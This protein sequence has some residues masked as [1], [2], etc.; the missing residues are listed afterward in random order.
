[1]SSQKTINALLFTG[2]ALCLLQVWLP[3]Y[4][5]T[6][7]GPS[8]LYNAQILHDLWNYSKSTDFYLHYYHVVYRPDPNWLSTLILALLLFIAKGAVA[9][10]IF[11]TLYV[12]LFVRGFYLL[13]AKIGG[14][15]SYWLLVIFL[16]VFP[17]E[18]AK[19]F[20]NSSLGIA[21][22]FWVIWSW[23]QFL[24]KRS[25][26]N[27]LVF[28]VFT[29]LI[30]F[31][32]LLAFGFAAF[33][34][35]AL[36]IPYAM[37]E[38]QAEG[39]GRMKFIA[40]HGGILLLLLAP[41][42]VLMVLF[43]QGEGGLHLALTYH[44]YRLV[45]LAQYKYLANVTTKEFMFTTVAGVVV[46]L[47]F[48]FAFIKYKLKAGV[49]KYD[50]LL[51]SLLFAMI[52]YVCFPEAFMGRL[53]LMTMRV[54]PLVG[55][56]TVACIAYLVP[57]GKLK[58]IGALVLFMC[59]ICLTAV[60][61]NCMAAVSRAEVDYV[62]AESYVKP[63][64]VVL[65]LDFSPSGTDE[66]GEVIADW[67]FLFAH[68]AQYMGTTKPLVILDNYEANMGYFPVRWNDAVNPYA[69]LSK[70]EGIEGV[71]P[72]VFIAGY[73]QSAGVT[74][75]YVLMW[76]YNPSFLQNEHFRELYAEI[77][78]GYHVVYTSASGKSVLLEVNR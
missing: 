64:S 5:L 78:A 67:N 69:H 40:R 45:E 12:V 70:G 3:A 31:T 38:G 18:L 10:K 65:P 41:F 58:N 47:L 24:E 75:D 59:F 60:R 22:Y 30:Y 21:F 25:V 72:Y 77:T 19:G 68:A 37:A 34:C 13:L 14:R 50:G 9:E 17:H 42:V 61:I 54:Q 8:H 26:I 43:T 15:N 36:L 35:G 11:L 7:D 2:F 53:I 20:Y 66:H 63:N 52:V 57:E 44:F 51:I 4:Y 56:M 49:N 48:C 39:K 46:L 16:F 76:G 29:A 73:K 23:L 62:S 74:I 71:P 28:F 32:H 55:A 1:L 6:G 33:T 27:A